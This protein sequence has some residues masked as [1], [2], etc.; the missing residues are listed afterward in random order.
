M[1]TTKDVTRENMKKSLVGLNDWLADNANYPDGRMIYRYYPS[2][3][4]ENV[5]YKMVRHTLGAFSM[6]RILK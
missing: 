4:R 3:D 5:E 2:S 6:A 1:P